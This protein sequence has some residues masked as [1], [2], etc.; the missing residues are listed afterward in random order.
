VQ[1]KIKHGFLSYFLSFLQ[2]LRLGVGAAFLCRFRKWY[3]G[4]TTSTAAAAGGRRVSVKNTRVSAHRFYK[5]E[6]QAVLF[7]GHKNEAAAVR[8]Q[9]LTTLSAK[10]TL[11]HM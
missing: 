9:S 5:P 7:F 3:H 10:R 1:P 11:G 2:S 4:D 8:G 6:K